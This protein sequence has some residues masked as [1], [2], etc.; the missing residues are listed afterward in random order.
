MD[1][2]NSYFG[3]RAR[4]E[5]AAAESALD[6]AARC[7][8]LELGIRYQ[9]LSEVNAKV[10]ETSA[11]GADLEHEKFGVEDHALYDFRDYGLD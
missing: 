9:Q 7:A 1:A 3:R 11:N 8:H 10:R 2:G 5:S 4:E 6:P